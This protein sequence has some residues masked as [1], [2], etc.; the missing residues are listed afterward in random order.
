MAVDMI[1]QSLIDTC[2]MLAEGN[3]EVVVNRDILLAQAL[4]VIDRRLAALED[5]R[6]PN[7]PVFTEDHWHSIW[8]EFRPCSAKWA[9]DT[10]H[11][12]VNAP[13]VL[14]GRHE[15]HRTAYI[16]GALGEWTTEGGGSVDV[17]GPADP[18]KASAIVDNSLKAITDGV[19]LFRV[20][21]QH[22][23]DQR[24]LD[25]IL[26]EVEKVRAALGVGE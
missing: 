20:N 4:Q 22:E 26:A 11:Q 7:T 12:L 15:R 6:K 2:L 18:Q 21:A 16:D 25:S 13:C 9:L 10:P 19:G 23:D 17:T 1:L 14:T 3:S 8:G 5:I 24:L